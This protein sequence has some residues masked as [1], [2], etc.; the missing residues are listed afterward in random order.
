MGWKDEN[1]TGAAAELAAVGRALREAHQ[2]LVEQVRRD[3]ERTHGRVAGPR[4]LLELLLE[5]PFFAWLRPISRVM[6]EIDDLLEA[7]A[8]VDSIRIAG[9]RER[10]EALVTSPQ[11]LDLLQRSPAA[12]M[13]HAGLRRAL[14]DLARR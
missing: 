8:P 12:V 11:Y 6:V 3:W 10:L 1:E 4:A 5:E 14:A 13:A 2:S 9:L 7:E